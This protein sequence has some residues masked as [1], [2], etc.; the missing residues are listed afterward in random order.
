[1]SSNS[2]LS[3]CLKPEILESE[4]RWFCPSCNSLTEST[5]ETSFI[6]SG[7]IFVIQF[8]R[9]STSHSMLIKD[10][11]IFNYSP[12]LQLKVLWKMKYLSPA[13]NLLWHEIIIQVHWAKG[14]T[15]VKDSNSGDWLSS[16]NKVVLTVPQHS[17]NKT[18]SYIFFYKK[19]K[20]LLILCKG[21]LFFSTLSLGVMTPHIITLAQV[22]D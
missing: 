20:A 13:N 18:T 14:I 7:S 12:E 19:N 5:R 15:V 1:M 22:E 2:F 8:S 21:F 10:Q 16:N 3:Q 17:L 11:Q 6:G 4:K 9:F